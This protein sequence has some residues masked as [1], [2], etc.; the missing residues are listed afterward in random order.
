MIAATRAPSA[1]RAISAVPYQL[2]LQ[3]ISQVVET[4]IQTVGASPGGLIMFFQTTYPRDG[5]A[6]AREATVV[7]LTAD[8]RIRI[9]SRTTT[10]CL[11]L[12]LF[13]SICL[14]SLRGRR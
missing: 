12:L 2:A 7:C 11:V 1:S 13:R 8:D 10:L 9:E 14:R 4:V 3:P 6:T 5:K